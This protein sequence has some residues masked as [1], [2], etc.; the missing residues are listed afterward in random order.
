VS[1]SHEELVDQLSDWID[2]SVIA[3]QLVEAMAEVAL[4]GEM[5][6]KNAKAIYYDFLQNELPDG[7]RRSV[8]H[9]GA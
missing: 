8:S 9:A 5:T 4:P 3:E 1:A 6:L 7:L 2:A